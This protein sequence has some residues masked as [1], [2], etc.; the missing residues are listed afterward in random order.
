MNAE[1]DKLLKEQIWKKKAHKTNNKNDTLIGPSWAPSLN[2]DS[3]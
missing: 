2:I 3:I 1:D